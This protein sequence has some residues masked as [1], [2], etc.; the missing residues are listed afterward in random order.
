MKR[1]S[2]L[3]IVMLAFNSIFAGPVD[4]EMAK[5]FGHKFVKANFMQKE[6]NVLDL[7]YTMKTEAGKPCFYVF[8]VSDYGF[9]MVSA[10]D[11]VRPILGYSE[12]GIFETENIAPG[13]G[14]MMED[15][16]E[17]IT[18]AINE[19]VVATPEIEAE[20]QSLDKTGRLKPAQ[21]SRVK[22]GPLCPTS[23]DQ[24][25]PY[26]YYCPD[27][28]KPFASN[29]KAVVGC[30]ATAMSQIMK[31][32][33]HPTQGTGSHSY[34]PNTDMYDYPEQSA[35][36]GETTYDWAYMP[37]QIDKNSP[38]EQ[39][40]A[41][42]LLGYHC[43]VA[44]EMMYDDDGTGSGAYSVDVPYAL[45]K[46]FG[47]AQSNFRPR[48]VSSQIWDSY[49]IDALEMRRPIFYAGTSNDGGGHAFVC[50]GV[51]EN[52]LF[53]YNYGWSGSGDGY[54][55]ST[56]IDYP[57]DVGAIFDIMPSGVHKNTVE[58]P[59]HFEV[60]PAG[61]NALSATLSWNNPTYALDGSSLTDIE[62]IVIER[63]GKV[64]HEIKNVKAG[65]K[66]SYVDNSVPC[67]SYFNYS[68]YA[69]VAGAHGKI[70]RVKSV[71][72][73]PTCKWEL[74]LQSSAFQGM[75]GAN[76]SIYNQA[77]ALI[78]EKTNANSTL[79]T[80]ELDLPYGRVKFVWN[81][82]DANQPSYN[83][84]MILKDYN[85]NTVF[86]YSGPSEKMPGGVFLDTVNDCGYEIPDINPYDLKCETKDNSVVLNWSGIGGN[87]YGYNVFRDGIL[88]GY[89]YPAVTT[90]TDTDV[91]FG[92]HCYTVTAM[93]DGGNTKESNEACAVLTEHCDPATD[94]KYELN[95][96]FKPK[97][98]W[99]KPNA[100]GLSGYYVMR[101]VGEDG[102]WNRVK[103]LAASK[104]DYTDNAVDE[105]DTWYFY[106]VQAY[107]QSTD[108]LSSP[109]SLSNNKDEY[110]LKFYYSET[111]VQDETDEKVG[112]YPNPA[113]EKITVDAQN[114]NRVSISNVM[115]Q[116][117]YETSASG[118]KVVVDVNDFP[119]GIYMIQVVTNEYE[120]TKRI[121]VSH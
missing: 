28:N 43:G 29:G 33:E 67:Y 63:E 86:N 1:L 71:P 23:W 118:D 68:V 107:Y 60:V 89:S 20:W 108:C 76:V 2:L 119:T 42:A 70:A 36:F 93:F 31:Y 62:K 117:V 87:H 84:T 58:A 35:N 13:L 92:G 78:T 85:G 26:N 21:R 101:K 77:D 116:K 55:A 111:G 47:Y 44:V 6:G 5:D 10:T 65:E 114:I 72:F 106:K 40:Q 41:V 18:Y 66:M 49:I 97:L 69:I 96:A 15:Y 9:I 81:P 4:V 50:D 88:I 99:N 25:W 12:D 102:E 98:S 14:F 45:Y 19:A 38:M 103:V 32:W 74:V 37:Y 53:H 3:L 52:G 100:P 104:T 8:N 27:L 24:Y 109:A 80:H 17:S 95:Q 75:R 64:I 82:A 90:Y 7:V 112:I 59:K 56:A 94:L 61:N 57:N 79:T 83:L 54:F 73:G 48:T 30:V 121:S 105:L 91:P 11:A 113:N 115:G 16:Q 46:Y 51:D 120:V 22:I 39:I 34:K 110:V